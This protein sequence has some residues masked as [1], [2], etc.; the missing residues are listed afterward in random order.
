[1]TEFFLV[2]S[3]IAAVAMILSAVFAPIFGPVAEIGTMYAIGICG[4]V[5]LWSTFIGH[6]TNAPSFVEVLKARVWYALSVHVAAAAFLALA[7]FHWQNTT[8]FYSELLAVAI[9]VTVVIYVTAM[10]RILKLWMKQAPYRNPKV[11]D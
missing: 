4:C 1:M 7:I 6:A 10:Y 8:G 11:S 2:G 3:L 9:F 5:T